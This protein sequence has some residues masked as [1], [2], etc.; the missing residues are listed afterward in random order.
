M[1]LNDQVWHHM[2]EMSDEKTA[3]SKR[4]KTHQLLSFRSETTKQL[5]LKT[6]IPTNMIPLSIPSKESGNPCA[7]VFFILWYYNSSKKCTNG[8]VLILG[9]ADLELQGIFQSK[10]SPQNAPFFPSDHHGL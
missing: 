2:G 5:G 9:I 6:G 3:Q 1:F 7:D 4:I 10:W 8:Q